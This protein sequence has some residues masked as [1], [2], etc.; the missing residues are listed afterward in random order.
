MSGILDKKSRIIDAMLTS[1]GRRQMAEGTF[2]IS[3]VTFTDSGVSYELDAENGHQDPTD[4]IYFEA[5]N[6][7]QDQITFEAD[8]EGK[9]LPLK[10]QTVRVRVPDNVSNIKEKYTE[11]TLNAGSITAYNYN[12][13]PRVK[14]SDV[15]SS[16][17][18]EYITPTGNAINNNGFVY[19]NN[20]GNL[21]ASVLLSTSL[22]AGTYSAPTPGAG[23][24]YIAYVGIQGG[25]SGKDIATAISGAIETFR[26]AGGPNVRTEVNNNSVY[27]FPNTSV[28]FNLSKLYPINVLFS[29]TN[30]NPI[31]VDQPS[32]GGVVLKDE[33][34]NADFASQIRGILT[35]SFD[36]FL[37][38]QTLASVNRVFE[39]QDFV[40]SNDEL[41]FDIG[42]INPNIFNTLKGVATPVD[43]IKS[44]FNDEK[45]SH[46]ENFMY[47]PPI[48]K[49]SDTVLPDKTDLQSLRPYFLGDYPSWGDN[50]KKLTY[51]SLMSEMRDFEN[52]KA[53]ITFDKT[54]ISNNVIGQF[55]EVN[56]EY[57]NKLDVVDFG[58]IQ[59]DT[60]ADNT[61]SKK[62]YFVGKTYLDNRGTVCFVN[63]F[64]LIFSKDERSE[65][66][67]ITL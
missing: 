67:D 7:P 64:T 65:S 55:F 31:T 28:N 26:I 36:N 3:Y 47:L 66:E 15:P 1:D 38:L 35:S 22:I 39:D 23:A 50:E 10:S 8:D 60:Q 32:V 42:R 58:I 29:G 17:L 52:V 53:D 4:R 25:S 12:S 6:L 37:D 21:T 19:S 33:I 49:T 45:M 2:E 56:N 41:N 27:L 11:A 44:I 9:L 34:V 54:S 46:L 13:G 40:L 16:K 57:V 18:L 24:P 61:S 51:S 14:A 43:S 30:I 59:D 62:V 5:C 20:T 63:M 48:V